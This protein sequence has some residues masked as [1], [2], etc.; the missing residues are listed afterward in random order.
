MRMVATAEPSIEVAVSANLCGRRYVGTRGTGES[1]RAVVNTP[2][3]DVDPR[4]PVA[5]T[6]STDRRSGT[7]ATTYASSRRL[8]CVAIENLP[9]GLP[10]HAVDSR[11]GRDQMNVLTAR[12]ALP[13]SRMVAFRGQRAALGGG[14]TGPAADGHRGPPTC[15]KRSPARR[16]AP[17]LRPSGECSQA[18]LIFRVHAGRCRADV[19]E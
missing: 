10:N 6:A 4:P 8:C 13:T 18:A 7:T 9:G 14:D 5:P 17:R 11:T 19:P 12:A 3:G 1:G 15:S 16:T 2:T